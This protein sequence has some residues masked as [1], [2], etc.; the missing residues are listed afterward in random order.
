MYQYFVKIVPTVY[1]NIS[2][3][4]SDPALDKSRDYHVIP[5]GT[6]DEPVFSHKAQEDL[7]S[8]ARRLRLTW[9]VFACVKIG[10]SCQNA[11]ALSGQIPLRTWH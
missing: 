11:R 2:G 6:E 7:E 5:V 3:S 1:R 4:V 9:C 10:K 8:T